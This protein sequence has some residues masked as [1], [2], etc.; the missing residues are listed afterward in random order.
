VICS[1]R[2]IECSIIDSYRLIPFVFLPQL[3]IAQLEDLEKSIFT[4][5]K[6]KGI[7]DDDF[8]SVKKRY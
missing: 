1:V 3:D 8:W 2:S 4:K 7:L 5:L 6:N